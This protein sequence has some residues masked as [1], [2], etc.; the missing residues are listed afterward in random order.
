MAKVIFKDN[1][2]EGKEEIFFFHV[3]TLRE[4]IEKLAHQNQDFAK[5]LERVGDAGFIVTVNDLSIDN[6]FWNW[7][8]LQPNDEVVISYDVGWTAIVAAVV[9][10]YETV[11]LTTL[12]SIAIN[13]VVYAI[14]Y[15]TRPSPPRTGGEGLN[16]FTSTSPTYNWS[17][18]VTTYDVDRPIAIE[19]GKHLLG[20][21]LIFEGGRV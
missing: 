20:G 10:V 15:F 21:N 7:Y 5:D 3:S 16:D 4:V 12:I 1:I 2:F 17:G 9:W 13:L 19:Y 18:I 14:N 8:P 6:E 11:G